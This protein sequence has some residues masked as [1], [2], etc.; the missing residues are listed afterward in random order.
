MYQDEQSGQ[1]L[2]PQ[3]A[4]LCTD[5]LRWDRTQDF[6]RNSDAGWHRDGFANAKWCSHMKLWDLEIITN[7]VLS[8]LEDRY[9]LFA[10]SLTTLPFSSAEQGGQ[11]ITVGYCRRLF[12]HILMNSFQ[13]SNHFNS[14]REDSVCCC[15]LWPA[16]NLR[17]R[18]LPP[19][20]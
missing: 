18:L 11:S 5:I 3:I 10:S 19:K 15:R 4:T 2:K 1:L 16:H 7:R 17:L 9:L 13:H 12:E 8:H 6:Y 20:F 14:N